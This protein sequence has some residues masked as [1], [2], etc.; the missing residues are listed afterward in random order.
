MDCLIA[1]VGLASAGL[2]NG[3]LRFTKLDYAVR[4]TG[5]DR[6]AAQQMGVNVD[7][8]NGT[9]FA[10]ASALGGAGGL[11]VGMVYNHIDPAMSFQATLKGVAGVVIDGVGNVP[12]PSSAVCC[13][14]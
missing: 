8:V 2:L 10:I 1:A 12:A 7:A 14:A 13:W 9:V 6:D 3:L 5:Q 4:A 11:L